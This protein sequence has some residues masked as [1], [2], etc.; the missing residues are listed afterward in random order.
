MKVKSISAGSLCS[1]IIDM[2]D[3]V[4]SFGDNQYGQLGLGNEVDKNIPTKIPNIKAKTISAKTYHSFI[5]S[6]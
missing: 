5:L 4:W 2:D 6:Y 3:N 1:L